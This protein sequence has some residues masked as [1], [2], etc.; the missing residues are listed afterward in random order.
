MSKQVK[1]KKYVYEVITEK[2]MKYIVIYFNS[3]MVS[4]NTI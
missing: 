3:L 1:K 4:Y 2:G